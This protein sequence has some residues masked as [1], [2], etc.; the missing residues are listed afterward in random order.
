VISKTLEIII[1]D[2]LALTFE[3]AGFPS[4]TQMAYRKQ[5]SSYD[6]V[7]AGQESISKFTSEGDLV[8]FASCSMQV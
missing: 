1:L 7:F 2:Q 8:Y 6:S 4:L 5:V 3:K